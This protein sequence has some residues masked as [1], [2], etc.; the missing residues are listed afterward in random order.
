LV[1]SESGFHD[2]GI[3]GQK[4]TLRHNFILTNKSQIPLRIVGL[5]S[6]CGCTVADTGK[7][8]FN[9][10]IK[11]NEKIDFPV[12]FSTGTG[13]GKIAATI[14][15]YYQQVFEDPSIA[16]LRKSLVEVIATIKPD[17]QIEPYVID[18]GKVNGLEVQKVYSKFSII[19]DQL[20]TLDI[21]E[22]RPSTD[23]ITTKL[24]SHNGSKYEYEIS[25]DVTSFV[26][27]Q[28]F[29][30]NIIIETNS[31]LIPQKLVKVCANYNA[32]ISVT[33]SSVIIS[34]EEAGNVE[35]QILIS[36]SVPSQLAEVETLPNRFVRVSFD[37]E[38]IS[39][40]HTVN[41]FVEPCLDADIDEKIVL[42]VTL[43]PIGEG[44]SV[45]K[46]IP[47]TMFRFRKGK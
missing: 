7:D 21:K 4:E 44:K 22:I 40:N 12:V 8:F 33:A 10:A 31:K 23:A 9:S 30:G 38:E 39:K 42:N 35:K 32:P 45:N 29:N 47:I 25:L 36:T 26:E 6:S 1:I 19:T 24:I 2:F 28:E 27:S 43:F 16:P 18:L 46:I 17:Y 11:T 20:E 37:A 13:Q 5:E 3:V 34:S 14:A 41:F 15:V